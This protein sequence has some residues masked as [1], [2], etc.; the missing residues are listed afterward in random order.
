MISFFLLFFF[1]GF[2]YLERLTVIGLKDNIMTNCC[3]SVLYFFMNLSNEINNTINRNSTEN[4]T[5]IQAENQ[6]EIQIRRN[7]SIS[8]NSSSIS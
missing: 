1:L 2:E 7:I 6:Q 4:I 5:N 8:I 3:Y